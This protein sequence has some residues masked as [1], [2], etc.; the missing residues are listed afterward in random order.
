MRDRILEDSLIPQTPERLL[1]PQAP[2]GCG[3]TGQMAR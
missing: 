1:N 3:A 2:D